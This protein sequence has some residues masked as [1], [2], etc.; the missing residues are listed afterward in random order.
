MKNEYHC[1]V[2]GGG[3]AG[4]TAATI[5]AQAGFSTLLVEREKMPRFHVGESLMPETFWTLRRIGV[6]DKMKSSKFVKKYS[7]Q[8][9]SH[10]GRE[11]SPFFFKEHDPRDCS[12]T[13]QVERAVFDKMLFDNAKEKGADT[14]DETRLLDPKIDAT[15][16]CSGARFQLADG[17]TKDVACRVLV[18]ATG[19]QAVV[20]NRLRIR[21]EDPRLRKA[22]VW[23][24]FKDARR[25]PG[26][27]GGATLILHTNQKNSW[28]WYIPLSDNITSIGCVGDVDYLLKGRGKPEDVFQEELAKCAALQE[29]IEDAERVD[30]YHVTKEFSYRSTQ[31]AGD[32]WV[33]IGDAFAFIDP[34]YSSGVFFALASG[35]LAADCVTEALHKNDTSAAQLGK[36]ARGFKD[37]TQWVRKLVDAFYTNEFS[38]GAFMKEHPEHKGNLVDVLIGR[39]FNSEVGQMFD[40]MT[41]WIARAK[42]GHAMEKQAMSQ[43]DERPIAIG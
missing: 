19:L 2:V 15:G 43:D 7:V 42:E 35:E 13:W 6:L 20:A 16:K 26:E 32:G 11:S 39:I 3:P 29:R 24:Y 27:N 40:D 34:I 1:V 22:A 25:D 36:W 5:L 23:S 31:P 28:F 17:T 21:E 4:C 38:F 37:G 14:F 18:D 10:T 9:V 8:F 30:S 41:P 33:L 12:Q